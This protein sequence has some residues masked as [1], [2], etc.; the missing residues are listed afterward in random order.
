[1]KMWSVMTQHRVRMSCGNMI[2]TT[3]SAISGFCA[4][5]YHIW[6]YDLPGWSYDLPRL[7]AHDLPSLLQIFFMQTEANLGRKLLLKAGRALPYDLPIF[8]RFGLW[9]IYT[10]HSQQISF[11]V[12]MICLR[13]WNVF[14]PFCFFPVC[15]CLLSEV[16]PQSN[17]PK[18]LKRRNKQDVLFSLFC[19]LWGVGQ[20]ANKPKQT[21]KTHTCTQTH[22]HTKKGKG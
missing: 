9:S 6:A 14:F 4:M 8:E 16:H 3:T 15:V 18:N 11:V 12:L 5:I 17:H 19:C 10:S 7:L 1:M 13:F 22:T 2:A 20:P 21:K